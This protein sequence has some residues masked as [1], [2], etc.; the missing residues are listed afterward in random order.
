MDNDSGMGVTVMVLVF[1]VIVAILFFVYGLPAMRR[2][3]TNVIV[4]PSQTPSVTA[5]PTALMTP[6]PT[7]AATPQAQI[8][9]ILPTALPSPSGSY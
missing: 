5:G 4:N 1:V 2:N 3:E 7:G 8:Q 9:I 6:T